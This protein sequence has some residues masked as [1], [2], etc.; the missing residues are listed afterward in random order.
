MATTAS[1][2]KPR[3]SGLAFQVTVV[4][5]SD[6]NEFH[7]YCPALKGLHVPGAT[8]A[9]AVQNARVAAQLFLECLIEDGDPIPVG[10]QPEAQPFRKRWP[11]VHVETLLIHLQ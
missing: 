7:A 3:H 6:G 11:V 10:V 2:A 8:I 4:V 9:E 1:K 5:E